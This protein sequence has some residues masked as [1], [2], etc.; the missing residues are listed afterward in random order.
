[1]I[2][3]L[4]KHDRQ[5]ARLFSDLSDDLVKELKNIS[6]S[7]GRGHE[8]VVIRMLRSTAREMLSDYKGIVQ[9]GLDSATQI[10]ARNWNL[11]MKP[12]VQAMERGGVDLGSFNRQIRKIPVDA[13]RAIY[14]RTYSDGL[15]LSQRIWSITPTAENGIA[16][17]VTQGLARGLHYDDPR[18]AEQLNR[19]LQP[20]RKGKTVR[21]TVKRILDKDLYKSSGG[22]QGYFEFRQRPVSFDAARLLRSEYGN[23]YRE[24]QHRS[25]LLNPAC[26]GEQW[27]LSTEHP[28]LGCACEDYAQHDEG[29][30][31]GVFRVE[32]TPITPHVCCLCDQMAVLISIDEFMTAVDDFVQYNTGP[33][34]RWFEGQMKGSIQKTTRA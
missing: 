33:L 23:A 34:A 28:D 7:A 8:R 15:F 17:I 22:K 2:R 19:F 29:L 5:I 30:G 25:A 20:V 1:M 12:Y 11:G 21:P 13:V 6:T 14:A 32:N 18:I 3:D 26:Y 27:L 16:K 9:D 4:Y 24:A 31:E 10:Q